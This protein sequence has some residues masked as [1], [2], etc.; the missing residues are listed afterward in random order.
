M[1]RMEE[2]M[3]HCMVEAS[4]KIRWIN[5]AGFEIVMS[6]GKHI[7]LDPFL[8]GDV[9]GI[10]CHPMDL[11]Q[12]ERCDYLFL[13]HIH[14]DHGA[15]VRRIQEKFPQVNIFV[16]DLSADPLCEWL[17]PYLQGAGRRGVCV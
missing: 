4:G 5:T 7:L 13:S 16:G 2:I 1:H 9:D 10:V 3:N 17:G 6:N 14:V 11:D 8:S 12:I 15:D